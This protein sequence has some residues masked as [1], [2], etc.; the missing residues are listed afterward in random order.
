M[1]EPSD[2]S[3]PATPQNSVPERANGKFRKGSSG[4]PGGQP[5]WLKAFRKELSAGSPDVAKL[6]LGLIRGDIHNVV[7]TEDGQLIEVDPQMRDRI[8]AAELWFTYCCPKPKQ[9][10]EATV[11]AGRALPGWTKEELLELLRA[12]APESH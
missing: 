9:E 4:N 12:N 10:V 8:K 2:S 7:R 5:K 6:I 11:T 3:G 1:A